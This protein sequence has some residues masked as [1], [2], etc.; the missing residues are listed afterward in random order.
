MPQK[1]LPVARPESPAAANVP[2]AGE[3][4]AKPKP[5]AGA[6]APRRTLLSEEQRQRMMNVYGVRED[7]PAF[8][9]VEI[10]E[11]FYRAQL[12]VGVQLQRV[13]KDVLALSE[14]KLKELKI[15]LAESQDLAQT[16]KELSAT[17]ERAQTTF[18][19]MQALQQ[20]VRRT[21]E[22]VTETSLLRKFQG[23]LVPALSAILA[24]AAYILLERFFS[25]A[26]R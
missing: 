6:P 23:M 12:M 11:E 1:P 5:A 19:Q 16:A 18:A 10:C 9:F 15:A 8:M 14:G 7:D 13:A 25:I 20:D 26:V 17:L 4:P 3:E 2:P 24:I 22:R 21:A